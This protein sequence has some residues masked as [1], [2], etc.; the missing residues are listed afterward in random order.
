M[1]K[2]TKI[3]PVGP[4]ITL[5]LTSDEAVAILVLTGRSVIGAGVI[6]RASEGVY[7]A[8]LNLPEMED[9]NT[10][11]YASGQIQFTA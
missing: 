4:S 9:V 8:L 10:D 6:G 11:S 5:E 3:L 7:H 1:A 2:A